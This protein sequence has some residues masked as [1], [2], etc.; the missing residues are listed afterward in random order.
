MIGLQPISVK[1]FSF[2]AIMLVNS[3]VSQS[4]GFAIASGVDTIMTGEMIGTL[5][6]VLFALFGGVLVNLNQ[7]PE[8]IKWIQWI[9]PLTYTIKALVQNEFSGLVVD[10]SQSIGA[11]D[12]NG[13]LLIAPLALAEPSLWYCVAINGGFIFLFTAVGLILFTKASAPILRL[14]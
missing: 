13:I 2:I 6:V 11:C 10:C 4:L 7:I 9:S 14:K 12:L 3:F 1:Y 5:F 8:A